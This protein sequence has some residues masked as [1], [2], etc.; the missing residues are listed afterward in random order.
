M[1]WSTLTGHTPLSTYFC[2]LIFELN[3]DQQI[4]EPTHKGGNLLDVILTNTACIENISVRATLSY[5]LSSDHYLINFSL[6]C[7]HKIELSPHPSHSV[8]DFSHADWDGMLNFLGTH[9]FTSY[10]DGT[11]IEFLWLYLKKLLQQALDRFVP[12]VT[13]R[14]HQRPKWFTPTLQHQLNRLHTLGRKYSKKPSTSSKSKLLDAENNFQALASAAKYEY[15]NKLIDALLINKN[16]SIYK[17]ISSL[18]KHNTFP[19]TMYY[20]SDHG[21]SDSDKAHLFNKYFFS[22]FTR[23]SSTTPTTSSSSIHTNTLDSISISSHEVYEALASLDP[24]KAHG[25][26]C[27]SPKIWK[28]CA[29]YLSEPLC[30]LYTKCLQN[31]SLPKEWLVHCITPVYKSGSKELMTNY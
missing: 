11:D 18:T 31:S 5:G 29:P 6:N 3:L 20:G 23:D 7:T 10:F 28:T 9:D 24:N 22:V 21:V 12:K 15:E 4:T 30:H 2:D 27:L 17:Y 26:D 16:Y 1:N 19:T 13:L 8:L 14:H 25:I